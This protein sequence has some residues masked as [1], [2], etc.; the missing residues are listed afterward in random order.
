MFSQ[1][2]VSI[3][4]PIWNTEKYLKHCLESI[5][6]QTLTDIEIICVN[7][8]ST[9]NC[10]NIIIEYAQ[11]DK[12]IQLIDIKHGYLSDARNKGIEHASGEYIYFCDSDDWLEPTAIEK[13]Y[14]HSKKHDADLCILQE[15]RYNEQTKQYMNISHRKI[16][17]YKCLDNKYY[18]YKDM[19][20]IFLERFEAWLHFYKRE[21][22]I[23]ENLYYPTKTFYEDVIVHFKS[24]FLASKIVF[25]QEPLYNYRFRTNSSLAISHNTPEKL[26]AIIY[27]KSI[28][29]FLQEKNLLD[30]YKM[31]YINMILNQ[32]NYHT[33]T[34]NKKYRKELV[35]LFEKF[36]LE[37]DN[38]KT[39]IFNS[40]SLK[41]KYKKIINKKYTLISDITRKT[42][43][44][45]ILEI[46][47]IRIS[48]KRYIGFKPLKELTK[49]LKAYFLFPWYIFKIYEH[50]VGGGNNEN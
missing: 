19:D 22:F 12:R 9:D 3:I 29:K 15:K 7:N 41:R 5:I 47:G 32:M 44:H 16:S 11:N 13:W 46:L 17:L 23:K 31:P 6:N 50:Q 30:R 40:H 26:D 25:Y 18:T 8:G 49:F 45:V 39:Y 35:K 33:C 37:N 2:K 21:F 28:Y 34:A 42:P 10:K 48:F 1:C 20:N 43:T 14:N 38:L 27:I 24:I 4:I 36:I